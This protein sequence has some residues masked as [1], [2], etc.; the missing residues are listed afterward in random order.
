MAVC[1]HLKCKFTDMT[2]TKATVPPC[3]CQDLVWLAIMRIPSSTCLI[4]M[5]W[6]S[7]AVII[8]KKL[9]RVQII[10]KP[11]MKHWRYLITP[12]QEINSVSAWYF[13][14]I[15]HYQQVIISYASN[16]KKLVQCY[17]LI[18]LLNKWVFSFLKSSSNSSISQPRF[19]KFELIPMAGKYQRLWSSGKCWI[20]LQENKL[21]N[22]RVQLFP[23]YG[24]NVQ[25]I[26]EQNCIIHSSWILT[27][28]PTMKFAQCLHRH[29]FMIIV[30]DF[31]KGF[32][33]WFPQRPKEVW[34]LLPMHID[35]KNTCW[36]KCKQ[37]YIGLQIQAT[38]NAADSWHAQRSTWF[39]QKK[40]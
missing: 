20:R 14:H 25:L 22:I 26:A 39:L 18:C 10:L 40:E 38:Q 16:F 35:A 5:N 3:I 21:C 23:S 15:W 8:H 2:E 34:D 4:P 17:A 28:S 19:N 33:W 11:K 9:K 31:M 6:S 36:D 37:K 24:E 27:N 1:F 12:P 13:I 7:P 32:G 30:W 29:I